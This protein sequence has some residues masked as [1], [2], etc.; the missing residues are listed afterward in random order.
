MSTLR[1]VK[2]QRLLRLPPNDAQGLQWLI[3]HRIHDLAAREP[4]AT[5][6]CTAD[7]LADSTAKRKVWFGLIKQVHLKVG[8]FGAFGE[9]FGV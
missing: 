2:V 7:F 5:R 3:T 6:S 8:R 4:P 1:T 9:V